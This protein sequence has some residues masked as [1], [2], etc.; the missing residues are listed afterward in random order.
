MPTST[1]L[2]QRDQ[3]VVTLCAALAALGAAFA[4]CKPTGFPIAD[5]VWTGLFAAAVT[6]A[7]ARAHRRTWL[8]LAG[9]TLV[10]STGVALVASAAAV[11]AAVVG[12]TARRR[13]PAL[14]AAIGAA[15]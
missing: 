3:N 14:G 2:A 9:V 8:W 13:S 6:F 11:V 1:N 15:S 7:T 4:G 12:A 5:A 10:A